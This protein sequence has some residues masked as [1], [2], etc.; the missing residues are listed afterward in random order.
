MAE[1]KHGSDTMVGRGDLTK[2]VGVEQLRMRGVE[3]EQ[4][5]VRSRNGK[6]RT[7]SANV[8]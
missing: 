8:P 4:L 5:G 3:V 6:Y 7:L 2:R 1:K